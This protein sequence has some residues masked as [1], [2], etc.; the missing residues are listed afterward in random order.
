MIVCQ[1]NG[2]TSYVNGGS[3]LSFKSFHSYVG[4]GIVMEGDLKTGHL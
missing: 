1:G 2:S 3:S 4:S